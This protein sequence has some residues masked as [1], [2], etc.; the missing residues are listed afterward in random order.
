MLVFR[1]GRCCSRYGGLYRI[2][3]LVI[4]FLGPVVFFLWLFEERT[5]T[6]FLAL[7]DWDSL[8]VRPVRVLEGTEERP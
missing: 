7:K 1:L 5:S 6:T 2:I 4:V 3:A 8:S